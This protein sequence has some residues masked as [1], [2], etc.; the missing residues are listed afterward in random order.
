M[1]SEGRHHGFKM[2]IKQEE[3]HLTQIVRDLE[4]TVPHSYALPLRQSV[5][6]PRLASNLLCSQPAYS[7]STFQC[8]EVTGM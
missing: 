7:A 2:C 1:I 8:V 5:M 3:R 6:Y 4:G